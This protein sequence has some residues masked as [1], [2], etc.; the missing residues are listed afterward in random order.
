MTNRKL[1]KKGAGG[2]AERKRMDFDDL[3]V[4]LDQ[5]REA[6]GQTWR[7]RNVG[8]QEETCVGVR[9]LIARST[10]AQGIKYLVRAVR[11]KTL[12]PGHLVWL[13]RA[14]VEITPSGQVDQLEEVHRALGD[15]RDEGPA[16]AGVSFIDVMAD[17]EK[18]LLLK[19]MRPYRIWELRREHWA[20]YAEIFDALQLPTGGGP[21][22]VEIPSGLPG[23]GKRS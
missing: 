5:Y 17:F 8:A 15:L 3:D 12:S 22:H 11:S 21:W 9:E 18:L 23:P 14:V 1:P 13:I 6:G 10:S 4:L 2:R 20:H 16:A 19:G 7:P